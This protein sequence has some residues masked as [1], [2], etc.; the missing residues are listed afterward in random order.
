M[1]HG[2]VSLDLRGDGGRRGQQFDYLAQGK[3][4]GE[5]AANPREVNGGKGVVIDDAA[6]L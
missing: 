5:V 1:E 6:G 2:V 4:L 3:G